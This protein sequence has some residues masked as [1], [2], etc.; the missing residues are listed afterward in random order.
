MS[1]DKARDE[2]SDN[3]HSCCQLSADTAA[4]RNHLEG[5]DWDNRQ[6]VSDTAACVCDTTSDFGG[7]AIRETNQKLLSYPV[8]WERLQ[9]FFTSHAH[10]K[11]SF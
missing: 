8:S 3:D 1:F 9:K 5:Q 7:R 2:E 4:T 11:Q 6:D 10:T